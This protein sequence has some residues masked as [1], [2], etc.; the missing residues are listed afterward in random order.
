[1]LTKFDEF[2]FCEQAVYFTALRRAI[3]SAI[4]PAAKSEM[5]LGSGTEVVGKL[6]DCAKAC[7]DATTKS[8]D[9][10]LRFIMFDLMSGIKS[11]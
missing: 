5:V 4:I 9:I 10:R 11:L 8:R 7:V 1:L 3:P 6:I 2:K